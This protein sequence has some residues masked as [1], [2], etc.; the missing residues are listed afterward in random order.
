MVWMALYESQNLHCETK[1]TD[2]AARIQK[3]KI[4]LKLSSEFRPT[5]DVLQSRIRE[6]S[7]THL[8]QIFIFVFT[9]STIQR[10]VILSQRLDSNAVDDF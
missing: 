3:K 7:K 9:G 2:R 10:Q 1:L 8:D 4:F 5:F 6:W